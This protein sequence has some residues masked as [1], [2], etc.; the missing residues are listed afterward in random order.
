M[1]PKEPLPYS[2]LLLQ[3]YALRATYLILRMVVTVFRRGFQICSQLLHSSYNVV[4]TAMPI[5]WYATFDWEFTKQTLLEK[6]S[7]IDEVLR[8]SVLAVFSF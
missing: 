6:P 2:L 7:I 5:C 1:L 8:R 4:F 3:K